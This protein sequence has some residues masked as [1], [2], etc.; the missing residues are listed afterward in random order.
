[1]VS[2]ALWARETPLL[3]HPGDTLQCFP[4]LLISNRILGIGGRGFVPPTP[5]API[6]RTSSCL[7]GLPDGV[8]LA[9]SQRSPDAAELLLCVGFVF[10]FW[11]SGASPCSPSVSRCLSVAVLEG[12]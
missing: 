2:L 8:Q 7:C 9:A 10:S 11:F 1:M 5:E 4:S 3:L 6:I 12:H